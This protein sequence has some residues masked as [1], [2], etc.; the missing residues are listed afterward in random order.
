[1]NYMLYIW[2]YTVFTIKILCTPLL[3]NVEKKQINNEQLHI[4]QETVNYIIIKK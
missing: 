1:M 2:L 3:T 4:N